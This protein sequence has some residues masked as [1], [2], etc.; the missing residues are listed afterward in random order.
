M[1]LKIIGYGVI[2]FPFFYLGIQKEWTNFKGKRAQQ[3]RLEAFQK[4]HHLNESDL[5]LFKETMGELKE[6]ILTVERNC[7]RV[8][9]LQE[10]E[11][12]QAGVKSAKEIFKELMKDPQGMTEF[13]HFLYQKMPSAVEISEKVRRVKENKIETPEIKQAIDEMLET[14]G[15]VLSRITEDYEEV[16][17]ED[18]KEV[19]VT[20]K[21]MEKKDE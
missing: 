14:F 7:H 4:K 10:I 21:M 18:S 2:L 9:E 11:K 3:N 6:Q 8:K 12:K 15:L 17:V 1:I 20:K 5:K 19:A 16:V 13:D